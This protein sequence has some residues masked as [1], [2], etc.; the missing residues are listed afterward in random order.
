MVMAAILLENAVLYEKMAVNYMN[1]N[2]IELLLRR[3][4]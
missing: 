4:V 1:G 2:S 3:L